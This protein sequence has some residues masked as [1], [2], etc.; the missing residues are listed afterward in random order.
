MK[1]AQTICANKV[2]TIQFSLTNHNGVVVREASS[3]P[4]SSL[5]GVGALFPKLERALESL[6]Q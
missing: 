6:L 5:H 3:K 1:K 4:V 2:V